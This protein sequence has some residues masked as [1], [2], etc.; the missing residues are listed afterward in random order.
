L[1]GCCARF[2]PTSDVSVLNQAAGTQSLSDGNF[3]WRDFITWRLNTEAD[4]ITKRDQAN[5]L[6]LYDTSDPI[7]RATAEQRFNAGG[8][9]G[10]QSA[11]AVVSEPTP[12]ACRRCGRASR[13]APALPRGSRKP[14]SG[15]F[16]GVWRRVS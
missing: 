13:L 7:A 6:T 10:Q 1:D 8:T 3:D 5:F 11:T 2:Q 14:C 16:A 4:L 15:W 9:T 12:T